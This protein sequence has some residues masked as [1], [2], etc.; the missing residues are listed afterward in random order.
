MAEARYPVPFYDDAD[1]DV[2]TGEWTIQDYTLCVALDLD[3]NYAAQA[4]VAAAMSP[5]LAGRIR[6][7]SEHGCFFAHG[8]EADIRALAALIADLVAAG[9]HPAAAPGGMDASPA[10]IRSWRA[11]LSW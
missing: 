9:P 5:E 2:D 11:P 4:A 10:F 8:T 1:I 6:L 3:D 7:D